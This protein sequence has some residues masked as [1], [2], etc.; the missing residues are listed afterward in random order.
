MAKKNK[1]R[2]GRKAERI[3]EVAAAGAYC[4]R[5]MRLVGKKKLTAR[6]RDRLKACV[7]AEVG[8]KKR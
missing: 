7:R 2:A 4:L 1:D 8:P 5:K 3:M 6:Q